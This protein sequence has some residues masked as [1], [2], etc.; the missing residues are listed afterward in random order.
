M[1]LW[2][3]SP[4][5]DSDETVHSHRLTRIFTGYTFDS[6]GYKVSLNADNKDS[7]CVDAQA[8]LS[9]C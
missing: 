5:E 7:D 2:I 1:Y 8:D 4:S 9:P 3:C 6:Q